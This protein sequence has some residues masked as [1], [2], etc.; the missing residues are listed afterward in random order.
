MTLKIKRICSLLFL[1]VLVMP[2]A[3]LPATATG[4]GIND[5]ATLTIY[6]WSG[7]NGFEMHLSILIFFTP[8]FL[9]FIS[10]NTGR[11]LVTNLLELSAL[12]LISLVLWQRLPFD[13]LA[14]G[15]YLAIASILAYLICIGIEVTR[16][17]SA[18]NTKTDP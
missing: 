13:R 9:L 3:Q 1:L 18:P 15:A 11:P 12:L 7:W 10:K 5:A 8:I 4:P 14:T 17:V 16:C 2:L 6:I